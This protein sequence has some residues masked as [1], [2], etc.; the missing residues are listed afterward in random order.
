[1]TF[2]DKS[3]V[4]RVDSLDY[5]DLGQLGQDEPASTRRWSHCYV[6]ISTTK[7]AA[8]QLEKLTPGQL[9]KLV[10]WGTR[11]QSVYA[12]FAFPAVCATS[13]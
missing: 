7:Q 2:A 10:T 6:L 1:M 3:V 4:D 8:D 13:S 9:E 5:E 12:W 11:L